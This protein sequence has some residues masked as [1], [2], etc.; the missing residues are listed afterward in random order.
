M[1]HPDISADWAIFT[2]ASEFAVGAVL[3]QFIQ[4]KWQSLGFFSK[5]LALRKKKLCTYD[6]ELDAVYEAVHHFRHVFEGRHVTVFTDH[7]PLVH[8]FHQNVDKATSWR[9]R[10]LDY[11]GQFT[12]DLKHVAGQDNVVAD[13]LSRVEAISPAVSSEEI[14]KEQQEDE[15]TDALLKEPGAL[16]ILY[17]RTIVSDPL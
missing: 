14:I 9:F 6:R 13:A 15:E 5:K 11:I 17:S 2:D 10:R 7:K 4:G 1:A 12:T 3:Q 16:E 8:A